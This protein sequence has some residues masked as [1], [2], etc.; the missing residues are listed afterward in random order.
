MQTIV[1]RRPSSVHG[2]G[3]DADDTGNVRQTRTALQRSIAHA[4][5]LH[6]DAELRSHVDELH[7]LEEQDA[8]KAAAEVS[9]LEA[10][11]RKLELSIREMMRDIE[12]RR[13]AEA[14]TAYSGLTDPP[15]RTVTSSRPIP[16]RLLTQQ[17]DRL[18]P[19]M[20]TTGP[21]EN[22]DGSTQDSSQVSEQDIL[23]SL[24]QRSHAT[25]DEH[26]QRL[27]S[28]VRQL[29]QRLA[30]DSRANKLPQQFVA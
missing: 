26:K 20:E 5:Q 30:H 3:G 9:R 29:R 24:Q 19:E 28:D 11:N 17:Q 15:H 1:A 27:M 10:E 22:G 21:S 6:N 2:A 4:E 13:M 7:K 25:F 23:A 16:G 18:H 8:L 14:Q 12:S